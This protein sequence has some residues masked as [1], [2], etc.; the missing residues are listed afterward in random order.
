MTNFNLIPEDAFV[1]QKKYEVVG[2]L[3]NALLVENGVT[4]Q[5]SGSIYASLLMTMMTIYRV[6][7]A[8]VDEIFTQMRAAYLEDLKEKLK[9][10]LENCDV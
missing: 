5:E 1:T 6:P 8:R 7:I 10:D 9:E 2:P 3:I 4:P